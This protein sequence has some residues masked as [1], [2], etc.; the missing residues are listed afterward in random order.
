MECNVQATA[1]RGCIVCRES[2][3]EKRNRRFDAGFL[4]QEVPTH[5][6]DIPAKLSSVLDRARVAAHDRTRNI[7]ALESITNARG[8]GLFIPSV[9]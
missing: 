5:S 8:C 1:A 6:P 9:G 3:S 2:S 4:E 7:E